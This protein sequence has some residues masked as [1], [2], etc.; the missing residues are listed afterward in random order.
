MFRRLILEYGF[1][2]V[3]CRTFSWENYILIFLH[4]FLTH[5]PFPHVFGAQ[6]EVTHATILITRKLFVQYAGVAKPLASGAEDPHASVCSAQ[7]RRL[8]I[9][10]DPNALSFWSCFSSTSAWFF[11]IPLLLLAIWQWS[12]HLFSVSFHFL[13]SQAPESVE[14]QCAEPPP[15]WYLGILKPGW[16]QVF[17]ILRSWSFSSWNK[18]ILIMSLSVSLFV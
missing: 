18:E 11:S 8:V 6:V 12:T 15:C 16:L 9:S 10:P 17:G 14:F 2:Y 3:V 1:F 5:Y 4:Q 13:E 7:G